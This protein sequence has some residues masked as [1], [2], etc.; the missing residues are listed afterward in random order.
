MK[1]VTWRARRSCP[2]SRWPKTLSAVGQAIRREIRV[3]CVRP[4]KSTAPAAQ[5]RAESSRAVPS[6]CQRARWYG[7]GS[8]GNVSAYA[9]SSRSVHPT[10]GPRTRPRTASRAGGARKAHPTPCTGVSGRPGLRAKAPQTKRRVYAVVSAD[11]AT[12]TA[13]AHRS[14]V[15]PC[16][17]ASNAASFAAKPSSGGRAAM[18]AAASTATAA[19]YGRERP[20]P[21]SLRRSRVPVAW[22]TMPVTRKSGALKRAWPRIIATAARAAFRLPVPASRVRKPSWLTVP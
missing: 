21:E 20:T 14:A 1:P 17:S 2:S 12:T 4:R 22:S 7:W 8:A 11:P 13:S 9:P 3:T 10:P 6:P 15:V 5:A 16:S 19:T 18:E